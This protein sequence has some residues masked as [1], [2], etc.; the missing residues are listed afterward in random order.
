M[1]GNAVDVNIKDDD[2]GVS[3]L[4]STA[5]SNTGSTVSSAA[6]RRMTTNDMTTSNVGLPNVKLLVD[7][8]IEEEL[9]E[10]VLSESDSESVLADESWTNRL[11]NSP[12]SNNYGRQL[13]ASDSS[14]SN[15]TR[16]SVTVELYA[17]N[18]HTTDTAGL[19]AE[20]I[21]AK[22]SGKSKQ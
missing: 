6:S 18:G 1:L 2:V 11:R 7:V 5:G 21:N 17:A 15:G 16:V 9:S 22:R 19:S 14:S 8:R 13:A 20:Q 10:A 12:G 3:F 4:G